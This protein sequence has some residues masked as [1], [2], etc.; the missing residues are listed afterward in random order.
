MKL[1]IIADDFTG[2]NDVALQL[3]KY[4]IDI[5]SLLNLENIPEYFVYSTETRNVK[6]MDAQTKLMK[7]FENFFE[8]FF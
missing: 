6:E 3:S 4:G 8:I 5:V 7:T 1:A 2:A